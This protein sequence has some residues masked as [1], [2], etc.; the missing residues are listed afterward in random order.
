MRT[1]PIHHPPPQ[2]P[3]VCICCTRQRP[4]LSS[5]P[6]NLAGFTEAGGRRPNL[7]NFIRVHF[8]RRKLI[9]LDYESFLSLIDM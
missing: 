1:P 6:K 7:G 4:S 3:S 8:L 5:Y 9:V 2:H